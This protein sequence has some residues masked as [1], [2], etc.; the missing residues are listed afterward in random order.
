MIKEL[1]KI[2]R[3][4]GIKLVELKNQDA[5]TKI[6]LFPVENKGPVLSSYE[7]HSETI[8]APVMGLVYICPPNRDKPFVSVG[9]NVKKG[10]VLCVIEAMKVMNEF[11]AAFDCE[12]TGI[13][14]ENGSIAEFGQTLFKVKRVGV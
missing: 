11:T 3:A 14:I 2:M 8:N 1:S 9:D 12:I 4:N 10:S 7:G 5:E 6:E 13:C